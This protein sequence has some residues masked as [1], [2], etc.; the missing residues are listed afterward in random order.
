MP[1]R[2]KSKSFKS[3]RSKVEG[4]NLS[5]QLENVKKFNDQDKTFCFLS[6][7]VGNGKSHL[8]AASAK[9]QAWIYAKQKDDEIDNFRS[10]VKFDELFVYYCNWEITSK[11]LKG[12]NDQSD[13]LLAKL[14]RAKFLVIDDVFAKPKLTLADLNNL[15]QI[16]DYRYQH[17]KK[18]LFTSNRKP[19]EYLTSLSPQ[20]LSDY[21]RKPVEQD[22]LDIIT[23][24]IASRL[25]DGCK[26]EIIY[27]DSVNYRLI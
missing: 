18:T 2:F 5:Q 20:N 6:G 13:E 9:K 19:A 22:D 27:F 3:F 4:N 11:K 25:F 21:N 24:R 17:D 14:E 12:F 15:F 23:D 16:I 26:K 8:A 10:C 7:N 1:K